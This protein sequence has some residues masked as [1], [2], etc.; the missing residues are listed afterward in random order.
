[1][2][3]QEA[4]AAGGPL[5]TGVKGYCQR[6]QQFA[7]ATKVAAACEK[8]SVALL[9][10]GPG[11][12]KTFAYLMPLLQQRLKT[13]VSTS[14]RSLQ[15]QLFSRDLPTLS[16]VLGA[17]VK[18]RMLKGRRNY[19]CKHRLEQ[20]LRQ[21]ELDLHSGD[22][23]KRQGE[24]ARIADY[25]QHS[26]DGDIAGIEKIRQSSPVWRMVTST[27]ENCLQHNC[28]HYD[29]C[30]VYRARRQAREAQIVIANHSVVLA[31]MVLRGE[32]AASLLPD[33][34]DA[35][36][37]DEAHELPDLLVEHLAELIDTGTLERNV[38]ELL[39]DPQLESEPEAAAAVAAMGQA[40][41]A[42]LEAA[43]ED[44]PASLTMTDATASDSFMWA[45]A[46]LRD[47]LEELRQMSAGGQIQQNL[48][49]RLTALSARSAELL[50][51]IIE[52]PQAGLIWVENGRER[53]G[54]KCAPADIDQIF[55]RQ[56]LENRAVIFT[57]AALATAGSFS[58]FCR[59]M[60]IDEAAADSGQWES[61]F[62]FQR[63]SL[64][65]LP[66]GMSDPNGRDFDRQVVEICEQ[67]C[68]ASRGRAFVLLST[69]KAM[70]YVGNSLRSRLGDDYRILLQ[71]E[72]H[73][74]EL[75]RMFTSDEGK[76]KVL[77]GTRTFWQGI[78]IPGAG[79]SLVII[80]RIPFQPP[81]DPVLRLLG[82]QLAE[83][84][85]QFKVL[86]LPPAALLLRQA[87]G[88]LLRS[89]SDCGLLVI[90]DPRLEGRSYGAKILAS[91][92]PM[93][94]VRDVKLAQQFLS[95][96]IPH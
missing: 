62:D 6:P 25:E 72:K 75:I 56:M 31:D 79:L 45:L 50:A 37:F 11:T 55:A 29:N 74:A 22:S 93:P 53:I 82:Q 48:A 12:G 70:H 41:R 64:M 58:A 85:N 9:E 38:A 39:A 71:Q 2:N 91:L 40:A 3:L 13:V 96:T 19:L 84:E 86:Q 59:R 24:L 44:W 47:R 92:P 14:T 65:L 33:D 21:G 57:S 7:M 23:G 68:K 49:A 1:M 51:R 46:A 15:D 78:D 30:H 42:V 8:A 28:Q 16:R 54:I 77:V 67:L 95:D 66:P 27:A 61:P 76:F 89:E 63:N 88:R 80:D 17:P 87:A 52:S 69:R 60:G 18:V 34:L 35:I 83:G 36:V 73:S 26:S 4:F 90:C 81:D 43:P 94:R 5:A 10:A 32:G 20:A